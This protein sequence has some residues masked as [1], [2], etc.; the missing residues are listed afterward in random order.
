MFKAILIGGIR[1]TVEQEEW[2]KWI[3]IL[4]EAVI[5]GEGY[6]VT[7]Y[8]SKG[9]V[10]YRITIYDRSEWGQCSNM[11]T[12][13]GLEDY[14]CVLRERIDFR[15]YWKP[16]LVALF[17]R[18]TPADFLWSLCAEILSDKQLK[19]IVRQYHLDYLTQ[20]QQTDEKRV[21]Q[22]M[23]SL[24]LQAS[25]NFDMD[26]TFFLD[27]DRTLYYQFANKLY[28]VGNNLIEALLEDCEHEIGRHLVSY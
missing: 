23:S 10:K 12:N 22:L 8:K 14:L 4:A 26:P 5:E 20:L 6:K 11:L 24:S 1:V 15:Q 7:K 21:R 16:K 3:T 18:R 27:D 25:E 17:G 19:H 28:K 9:I 2:D 13:M